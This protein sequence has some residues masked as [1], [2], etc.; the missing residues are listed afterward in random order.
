MADHVCTDVVF[1]GTSVG[2]LVKGIEEFRQLKGEVVGF[3][4]IG[5]RERRKYGVGVLPLEIQREMCG[6][7]DS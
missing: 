3:Q 5:V 2:S 1:T 4:A 6:A 7:R